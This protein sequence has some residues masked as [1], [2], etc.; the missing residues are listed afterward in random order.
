VSKNI[1]SS[2]YNREIRKFEDVYIFSKIF[3]Q[4]L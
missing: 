3:V 4:I 2:C 1:W